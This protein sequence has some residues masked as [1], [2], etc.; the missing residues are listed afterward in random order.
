MLPSFYPSHEEELAKLRNQI[1]VLTEM[2]KETVKLPTIISTF[3]SNGD[4]FAAVSLRGGKRLVITRDPEDPTNVWMEIRE[5]SI[6]REGEN[7]GS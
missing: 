4:R 2:L 5:I 3:P 7:D 1:S 6:L